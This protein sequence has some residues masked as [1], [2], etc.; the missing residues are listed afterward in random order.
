MATMTKSFIRRIEAFAQREG[1]DLI[2]FRKGQRKEDIAHEYLASFGAEEGVLFIGKAQEKASVVRTERR[3]NPR[4]GQSY[5]WLV[6]S[7]APDLT[8]QA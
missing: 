2:T 7:S 1:I 8:S 3:T 4:T 5:A 6:K